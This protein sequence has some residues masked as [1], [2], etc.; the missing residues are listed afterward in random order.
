MR[1]RKRDLKKYKYFKRDT[2][3]DS[4]STTYTDW[5]E[6]GTIE[7]HIQPAG[8]KLMAEMYGERLAYMLTGYAESS[9]PIEEGAGIAVNTS[10]K[11]D[12]RIISV[13]NWNHKVF[14]LEKISW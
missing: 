8:G 9:Q 7:A 5:V 14:T 13:K 2:A 3:Q 12:Y 6:S 1:L 10:D 4:D 11:P